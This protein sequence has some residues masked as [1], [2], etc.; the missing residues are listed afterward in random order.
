MQK[1][2]ITGFILSLIVPIAFYAGHVTAA[3]NL[4]SNPSLETAASTRKTPSGWTAAKSGTNT[5]S[6]Y[7]VTGSAQN[8]SKSVKITVSAYTN[9]D[10][11]WFF[12]PV[13]VTAGKTYYFTNYYKATAPTKTY[14]EFQN[15]AGIK[16]YALLGNNAA[17][18]IWTKSAYS[19][20]APAGAVKATVFQL[21]AAKGTLQTDNY[22]LIQ[23]PDP[24]V[25]GNVP[26]SSL[27]ETDPRTN[28]PLGWIKEKNGTNSA[29]FTYASGTGHTGSM[30]VKTTI[31]RY[32]NGFARWYFAPQAI[33]GGKCY[34]FSDWYKSNIVSQVSVVA[35]NSS[36]VAS[37]IKLADA[38]ASTAWKQYSASICL[39]AETVKYSVLHTISKIGN[40]TLDDL[41]FT[42][43][44]PTGTIV[45][46]KITSGGDN[47]F[48][49]TATGSGYQGFALSNG[50]ENRQT[51][52]AGTYSITEMPADNWN[53]DGGK[54]DNSQTPNNI[55]I[56]DGMTVTCTF[57]NT[58]NP[59]PAKLNISLDVSD[60]GKFDLLINGAAEME[61]LG[62]STSHLTL[63]AGNYAVSVIGRG[64]TNPAEYKI[65]FGGDCADDG[66]INLASNDSKTCLIALVRRNYPT[67]NLL[68][69]PSLEETAAS[70]TLPINWNQGGWGNNTANY[71]Y[72]DDAH[73]GSKS[74]RVEIT[75]YIDG[76][77][78]WYP[79]PVAVTPG[80]RYLIT[81]WYKSD[82]DTRVA[83]MITYDNGTDS[84]YPEIGN[85]SQSADWTRFA[86]V[87]TAP[88]NAKT[89]TVLHLIERGN[90]SLTT[91]DYSI[92]VAPVPVGNP[93]NASLEI[94][95][96]GNTP[97][98][99]H[100]SAWSTL[101]DDIK[102]D[103]TY[104]DSGHSGDRS[105]QTTVT[106]YGADGDAKWYFDP[107]EVTPGETYMVSDW[108]K[109]T[110]PTH[111]IVAFNYLSGIP[112]YLEL[113][114][115]PATNNS[116]ARYSGI[117]TVPYGANTMTILHSLKHTGTLITDDYSY[118][119]IV[120]EGFTRPIVSLTFDDS[121]ET[122]TSTAIPALANY[123]YKSTYYFATTYLQ[124]NANIDNL[125]QNG[126]AAVKSIYEQGHEIGSHSITHPFLTQIDSAQLDQELSESKTYLEN[127]VGSGNI[128]SFAT[129]YGDYNETVLT[130]IKKYYTSHRPTDEGYNLQN[131]YDI[132]R[133]KVQN[134]KT[135]TTLAEYQSWI[136]QAKRDN[137]WLV[138][139]Y[140]RVTND[141]LEPY[142]TTTADF[143]KQIEALKSSGI[144]VL[145]MSQA[146]TE[147]SVQ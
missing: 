117:V 136:D 12:D 133:I 35:Y 3:T 123:G 36:N 105:V 147:T 95:P 128:K 60:N 88:A 21:L 16:T 118:V 109:A 93:A 79:D 24:T 14:A 127:I 101:K 6:F 75:S 44:T 94:S 57:T 1:T 102:A 138:I 19:F 52:A 110:D 68:L 40:L 2:K 141:D 49:F 70:S 144:T 86:G 98:L 46:K 30:S 34:V 41:S 27:E 77:A 111:F 43:Q 11:R 63:A 143:A 53:S 74:A 23:I 65:T 125:G 145:P 106:K 80:L 22:S 29:A 83:A 135:T 129:P 100:T 71:N 81:D 146:I 25:N 32:T 89:I 58:Y 59:G 91:D 8:G 39:P 114:T 50:Q 124:D 134:I 122:N 92:T 103:F 51:L 15:S 131:N 90:C 18:I 31:T 115:A 73:N 45:V 87:V 99:W 140:H 5:S 55:I 97:D 64:N 78:K 28:L 137:S 67:D 56:A 104:L 116:W 48:M 10:T 132:D 7:Y 130:A 42:E 54:C 66:G 69:N 120:P 76:D 62:N 113:G 37:T 85:A 126:P 33:T 20:T 139:V 82:C 38:P 4:I 72:S 108:Y 13:E 61:N 17:K 96:A 142:D 26:N 112:R 119:K 47:A 84:S 9:G 107:I 121:W